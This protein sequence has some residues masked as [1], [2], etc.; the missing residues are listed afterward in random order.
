MSQ[1]KKNTY[2]I[3]FNTF[4]DYD[5]F[6]GCKEV[7]MAVKCENS[8]ITETLG[9]FVETKKFPNPCAAEMA[10]NH[11]KN[12]EIMGDKIASTV[13]EY[14]DKE[15]G[16]PVV[17]LYPDAYHVFDDDDNFRDRLNHASRRDFKRQIEKRL[18]LLAGHSQHNR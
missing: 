8:K 13:I 9:G 17:Q 1:K 11:K 4:C 3:N 14:L 7:P 6:S 18:L 5:L 2:I 15:T 10:I 12:S 16:K